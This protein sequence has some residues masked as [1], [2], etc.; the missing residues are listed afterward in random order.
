MKN[1]I[2][3]FIGGVVVGV[4]LSHLMS[5]TTE[6]PKEGTGDHTD[7]MTHETNTYSHHAH[8]SIEVPEGTP[9]PTLS[10]EALPDAK[11][12][13]NVRIETTNFEMLAENVNLNPTPGEGHAHIYVNDE[14]ISRVYGE[15]F[16]LD[17]KLFKAGENTIKVSLNAND[18]SQWSVGGESIEIEVVVNN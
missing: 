4:V 10:I 1:I 17:G 9:A 14:K 5:V 12:G 15:W 7:H 3:G 18:H 11:S 6:I 8:D 2:I 16:H 13:Y